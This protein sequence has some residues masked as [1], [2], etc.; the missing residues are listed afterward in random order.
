MHHVPTADETLARRGRAPARQI[1]MAVL[2]AFAGILLSLF[3]F[4]QLRAREQGRLRRDLQQAADERVAA[5]NAPAPESAAARSTW[6]PWGGMLACLALTALL[7]ACLVGTAAHNARTERL[8]LQLAKARQEWEKEL[9]DRQ[10]AE[11]ELRA[12]QTKY[13]TLYDS[14]SDAIMVLT[15]E[16]G[17]LSGNPATVALFRCKDEADFVAYTPAALSPEYQ[18]DGAPSSAKADQVM[19]TAL[20]EGSHFFEWTHK[21]TDGTEFFAT[22]LL[23]RMELEGK[24]VLQATVRDITRQKQA[25]SELVEA[26][27]RAEV[28]NNAKSEFLARMSHEIRTP[29]TAILG[30]ADLLMDPALGAGD[31][32]NY[33]AVVRRNGE[34]LL[35]LINDILDLSRIE[36][37]KLTIEIGRCGL[38]VLLADVAGTMRPRAHERG[39]ALS[40][41]YRG[42]LPET[43]AT[44]GTRLRQALCNLVGNAVKFTERGAVRIVASFVPD[45]PGG[46]PAVRIDV[47]DT[48]V[49]IRKGLLEQLFQP[50]VQGNVSIAQHLGGAGLGLVI[51]RHIAE[52]LHGEL[53]V[54]STLGQGSTFSLTVPAG[55]LQG[56]RMLRCPAE[57]T[58]QASTGSGVPRGGELAGM[59]ILVAED[60]ADN[61]ALIRTMLRKAGAEVVLVPNGRRALSA[62]EAEPF[63]AILMDV[64]MPEMDGYEATRKLREGGYDRPILALTANAMSRDSQR[65]AAA[66]CDDHLTKPIHRE[67]LIRTIARHARQ[68]PADPDRPPP[69]E[70][71]SQ[72]AGPMRSEFADDPEMASILE[73]FLARL[74][75]QVD[76]MRRALANGCCDELQR[77]AHKLK[78]SAGSYGYPSLTD[79]ARALED[80]AKAGDRA[81]MAPA[82]VRVTALCHAIEETRHACASAGAKP[83]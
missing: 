2:A 66:G 46:G 5:A 50:F 7:V 4:V 67:Q 71:Q 15:P 55:D 72:G 80:A 36:A 1:S 42:E 35:A 37:G 56:V 68:A 69:E 30:Y 22:V 49:G 39:I 70:I 25:E 45:W 81:A 44:D 75:G 33:L 18:P 21:R 41:E 29:M 83:P 43:I 6:Q 14:S 19:A 65:S 77:L 24:T 62:A 12:S 63:D 8:A 76:A 9:A 54:Q 23:T 11:L 26:R 16:E 60:S 82:L 78:G 32:A 31:R 17:F 3:V 61:Q 34:H 48:G 53:S 73:A 59:R 79:A 64:N 47:I 28:A 10:R 40:V 52:L 27:R 38:A 20:R 13:R 74:D 51:S 57:A 58:R